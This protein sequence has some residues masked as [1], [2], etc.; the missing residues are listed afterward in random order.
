MCL[1]TKKVG[2]PWLGGKNPSSR[3]PYVAFWSLFLGRRRGSWAVARCRSLLPPLGPNIRWRQLLGRRVLVTGASGG[4]GS[5]LV[6]LA[7]LRGARV[8]AITAASKFNALYS[9]GADI[10]VD[11]ASGNLASAVAEAAA[12]RIGG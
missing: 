11:R 12:G 6:Q 7:R 5:A 4:V 9:I 2:M 1:H 8:V 10:C 3:A